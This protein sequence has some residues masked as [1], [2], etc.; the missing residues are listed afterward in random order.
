MISFRYLN[1]DYLIKFNLNYFPAEE[2][3]SDLICTIACGVTVKK[4]YILYRYEIF[5]IQT[6]CMNKLYKYRGMFTDGSVWSDQKSLFVCKNLQE[7]SE[8]GCKNSQNTV[9]FFLVISPCV[10][11]LRKLYSF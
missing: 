2:R 8:N 3:V 10:W 7:R 5:L 9:I 6:F 11:P 1:A 4:H